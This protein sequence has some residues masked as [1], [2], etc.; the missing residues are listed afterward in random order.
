MTDPDFIIGFI[1]GLAAVLGWYLG[2]RIYEW[3]Q[4]PKVVVENYEEWKQRRGITEAD[5]AVFREQRK[6]WVK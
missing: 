1:S 5:E 6:A 4:R 2:G 3:Q